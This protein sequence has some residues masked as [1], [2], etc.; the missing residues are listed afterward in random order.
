MVAVPLNS[1]GWS[2]LYSTPA[3][4]LLPSISVPHPREWVS[5]AWPRARELTRL[6]AYFTV[7]GTHR[8]PT[9]LTVRY[10]DGTRYVPVAG[11]QI[12]WAAGSNQPTTV[13][14]DP[15]RTRRLKIDMQATSFLQIAEVQFP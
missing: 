11:Q 7:D 15:V 9:G 1:G 4:A 8:L 12:Q 6:T 5:F 2:N 10:W 13:T 14:F 3:T